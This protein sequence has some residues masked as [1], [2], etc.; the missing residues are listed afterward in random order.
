VA[1]LTTGGRHPEQA[2]RQAVGQDTYWAS[3]W[4]EEQVFYGHVL[5]FKGLE[6]GAVVLALNEK[7]AGSG[8]GSGCTSGSPAPATSSWCAVTIAEVGG[9]AVLRRLR[10][11]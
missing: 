7:G 9:D 6:R 1:L 2:Q 4:D 5:G 11:A 10:G 8:R 3:F